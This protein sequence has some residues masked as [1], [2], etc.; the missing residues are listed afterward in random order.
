M[1][2]TLMVTPICTGIMALM[3]K[4]KPDATSD[5]VKQA[6]KEGA[7][8]WKGYDPNV[9]GD[10]YVNAKQVIELLQI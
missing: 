4:Y 1:S 3:L 9:H 5:E 2:G 6:L 10:G 8:L 7:V